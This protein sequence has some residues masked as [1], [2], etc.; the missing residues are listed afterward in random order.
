MTNQNPHTDFWIKCPKCK[1]YIDRVEVTFVD[2]EHNCRWEM[3]CDCGAHL[4]AR[5]DAV[6]TTY[7]DPIE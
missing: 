4:G 5:W 6:M 1:G 2:G 3:W 7:A